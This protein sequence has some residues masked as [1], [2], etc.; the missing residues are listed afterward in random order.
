MRTRSMIVLSLL[1]T[2]VLPGAVALAALPGRGSLTPVAAT[3]A[4]AACTAWHTR[5]LLSGQGWLENLAF[6]GSG[7]MTISALTKGSIL[8]LSRQRHL[9]TLLSSVFAPGGQQRLGRY[10][11]FNTGDAV[12]VMPNGTIDRLDLRTGKRSTWARGLTMPN[13]LVFLPNGDAVVSR[14]VGSGT[15]LTRVPAHDPRH[16]QIE[17]AK[18]DDTNGLAVDPSAKW[19]YT[20]RTFSSDGEVDRISIANPRRVQ[21]VGH[22]GARVA[23]DDMTIDR[24]GKLYIAGFAAGKIYRLDPRT[25]FACAIASGLTQPTSARFGGSGWQARDLYVTDATGHLTELAPPVN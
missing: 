21:V 16:P 13:G 2:V 5:T 8:R 19:L 6:D 4:S 17:W 14:D 25:H 7:S 10:L 11:Y 23:P 24:S 15:G 9:S 18:V 1:A 12:P 3:R 20:D 22:L